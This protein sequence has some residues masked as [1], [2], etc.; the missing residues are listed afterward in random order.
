M[1]LYILSNIPLNSI[2]EMLKGLK[3]EQICNHNGKSKKNITG[4]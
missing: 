2:Q 1:D 3:R 4:I